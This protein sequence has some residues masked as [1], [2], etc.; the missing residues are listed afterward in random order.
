VGVVFCV[1]FISSVDVM[2]NCEK[3]LSRDKFFF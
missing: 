3:S 2:Q 1:L